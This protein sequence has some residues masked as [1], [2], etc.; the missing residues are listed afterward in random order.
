MINVNPQQLRFFYGTSPQ[1]CPY[2]PGRIETKA[3]TELSCDDSHDFHDLLSQAGFRRSHS[4][5]YKPACPQCDACI[6]ARVRVADF[7]PS[8]SMRRILKKNIDLESFETKPVATT[9]HFLLFQE[10][11][12]ARHSG[13]EMARMKFDDFRAMI[14][15]SPVDTK[16]VEYRAVNGELKGVALTDTLCDGISGVYTFFSPKDPNL[17]LG[18]FL[19]LSQIFR[20]H[21]LNLPYFYLGYWVQQSPKM[22]Y[23]GRFLP[24]EILTQSGWSDYNPLKNI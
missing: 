11:E 18:T 5:A 9:E 23:K 13:G 17:S 16:I 8:K 15:E 20:T 19:I 2:I 14:E 4:L 12:K 6:P 1:A 24:M 22:S 7:K 21:K 10:Y 3:I